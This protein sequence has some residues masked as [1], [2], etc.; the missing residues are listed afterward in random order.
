MNSVTAPS[1]A[2]ASRTNFATSA[3]RSVKPAPDVCTVSSDDTMV[4]AVTV[5]GRVRESDLGEVMKSLNTSSRRTPGPI[6]RGRLD[7]GRVGVDSLQT[8]SSGGYG[9]RRSP[10]RLAKAHDAIKSC[11]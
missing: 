3:V 6:R 2:R 5:G 9:S 10:G 7:F 1:R 11:R 8:T 4:V